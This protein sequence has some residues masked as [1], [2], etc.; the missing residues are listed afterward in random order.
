MLVERYSVWIQIY[1]FMITYICSF[2]N[3]LKTNSRYLNHKVNRRS[4]DLIEVLLSVEE[5]LFYDRKRK[6]LLT[7]TGA[8]SKKHEGDRHTR[9]LSIDDSR[10]HANVSMT[11]SVY[12]MTCTYSMM[13]ANKGVHGNM[14]NTL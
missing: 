7:T 10:V 3:K 1:V 9:G 14:E 8:A 13:C 5:D 11:L 2:F 12:S 4:D 6:E